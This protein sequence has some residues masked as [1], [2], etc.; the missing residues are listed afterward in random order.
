MDLQGYSDTNQT[1]SFCLTT[2]TSRHP[3]RNMSESM[4]TWAVGLQ[5]MN[6]NTEALYLR[7]SVKVVLGFLVLHREVK[8]LCGFV[9]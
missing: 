1:P 5:G 3:P 7:Q 4:A 8:S 2:D 6:A 9:K